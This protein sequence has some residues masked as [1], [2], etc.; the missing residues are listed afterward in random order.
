M[1]NPYT[2]DACRVWFSSRTNMVFR[3]S[4]PDV[5]A[6][7]WL[8]G[9]LERHPSKL[10]WKNQLPAAFKIV[11]SAKGA[12]QL[13]VAFEGS[14]KFRIVSWVACSSGKL[15]KRQLATSTDDQLTSAMRHAI[16]IQIKK[17][18]RANTIGVRCDLCSRT[19]NIEVDHYPRTFAS[20]RDEFIARQLESGHQNPTRFAWHPKRGNNIFAKDADNKRWKN[21]WQ[22][23]HNK[24]ANFRYLCS[25]C[26]KCKPQSTSEV[27]EV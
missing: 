5:A 24:H 21:A 16:R 10:T 8:V 18:R 1:D 9:L 25:S 12:H 6:W 3:A 2:L 15:K 4:G 14:A 27:Q 22:R 7:D 17:F 20:L 19:S 26:N 11:R 13:N 23:F